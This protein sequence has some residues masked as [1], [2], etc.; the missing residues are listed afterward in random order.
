MTGTPAIASEVGG[1]PEILGDAGILV[2]YGEAEKFREAVR[3]LLETPGTA[4]TLA[5]AAE[6][7]GREMPGSDEVVADVLGVYRA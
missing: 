3:E 4:R 2:P 6:R 1:I 5:A 7:R